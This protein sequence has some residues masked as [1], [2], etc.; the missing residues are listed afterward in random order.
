MPTTNQEKIFLDSYVQ[1]RRV[2]KAASRAG[3][4][5]LRVAYSI[6]KSEESKKYIERKTKE[7]NKNTAISY[8]WKIKTLADIVDD[9][10][11]DNDL[12]AAIAA[13]AELNRMQGHYGGDPEEEEDA[14]FKELIE[15]SS[16]LLQDK[17]KE[18]EYTEEPTQVNT[19]QQEEEEDDIL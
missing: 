19:E 13:I 5:D 6:L 15:V 9:A 3:I 1:D 12:R 2:K 16:I 4:R 8:V 17:K 11:R 14:H 18:L 7:Y 10:R